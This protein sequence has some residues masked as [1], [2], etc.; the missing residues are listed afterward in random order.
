VAIR[1]ILQVWSSAILVALSLCLCLPSAAQDETAQP[2]E[3]NEVFLPPEMAPLDQ[4]TLD[5][6]LEAYEADTSIQKERPVAAPIEIDTPERRDR[7]PSGFAKAI[8]SFFSAIGPLFGYLAIAVIVGAV[9]MALYFMFGESLS[10]R[11]KHRAK[12]A[13]PEVS[14]VPDLRPDTAQANALLG[15]AD[16]LAAEGRYSE[17]VH[18]LLFRS[19]EHIQ[20]KQAV[21]VPKSLTAREIGQLD[22]LSPDVRGALSPIIQIV[23]RSYFGGRDVGEAEWLKARASYQAFAFGDTFALKEAAR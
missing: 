7:E 16:T 10:L 1:L 5:Q 19:I 21:R 3:V 8:A 12:D 9:L 2:P 15:D 23:E 6:L 11:R 13:G 4:L 18:M 17:A 20:D 22:T 14:I